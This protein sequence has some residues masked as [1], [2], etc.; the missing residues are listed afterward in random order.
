MSQP[1]WK[2]TPDQISRHNWW[3][4]L[5]HPSFTISEKG[6]TEPV[7][8]IIYQTRYISNWKDGL[9]IAAFRFE[10]SR[11]LNKRKF[12][13]SWLEISN[14]DAFQLWALLGESSKYWVNKTGTD[15]KKIEAENPHYTEPILFNLDC[16][17]SMLVESFEKFIAEQR[18]L[19]KV[20]SAK[21]IRKN[22]VS[23]RWLEVWDINAID[24]VPLNPSMHSMKSKAI[25]EAEKYLPLTEKAFEN[26]A[27]LKKCPW[28]VSYACA[29]I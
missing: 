12:P 23:W 3:W 7:A 26:A 20:R 10:L 21:I 18:I 29:R 24:G 16:S 25:K 14:D 6:T 19:K 13:L 15:P 5:P 1:E 4:R 27:E 28:Y 2:R 17:D 8:Q 11:R 22:S 9:E